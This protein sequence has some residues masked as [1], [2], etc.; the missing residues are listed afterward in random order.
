MFNKDLALIQDSIRLHSSKDLAEI[1]E[2]AQVRKCW[3][4]LT[5]RIE[6]ADE[7]SQ[8]KNWNAKW[9]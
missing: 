7:V 9:Q 4:G 2:L 1:T 6:N 3:G 8:T 5:S